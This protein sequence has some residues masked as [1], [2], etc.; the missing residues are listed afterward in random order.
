MDNA[1]IN[2]SWTVP[3]DE[4]TTKNNESINSIYEISKVYD[5]TQYLHSAAG[6]PVPSMFINAIRA[7]SFTTWPT[8]IAEHVTKYLENPRQLSKDT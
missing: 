1:I 5:A 4:K 2:G 3:L 8:L 7:G 6:S